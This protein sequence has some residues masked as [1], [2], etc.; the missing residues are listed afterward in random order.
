MVR[1]ELLQLAHVQLELLLLLDLLLLLPH[2]VQEAEMAEL[3]RHAVPMRWL[4]PW[5]GSSGS[6]GSSD[7]VH[8]LQLVDL[9]EL[10]LLLEL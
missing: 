8:L 3:V 6:G 5:L 2:L 7:R 10:E 4:G 9:V 1:A